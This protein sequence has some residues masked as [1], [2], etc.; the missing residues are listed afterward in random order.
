[1]GEGEEQS[2][3][4]TLQSSPRARG[5]ATKMHEIAPKIEGNILYRMLRVCM[6]CV[7]VCCALS[8][9]SS[10]KELES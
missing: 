6:D 9:A 3:W 7:Q 2:E 8:L 1:M 5:F 4:E 10:T